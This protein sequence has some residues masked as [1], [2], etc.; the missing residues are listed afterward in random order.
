MK[1]PYG[2]FDDKNREYVITRPDTPLPWLNYI[3]Q[4]QYFGLVTNTSGGYSF[5]RDA[6]LRRLT[7]YRYNDIPYDSNGRYLYICDGKDVWNPGWKPT[8]TKLD[9]YECRH[10]LG[11]T[12]F[13]SE[14]KNVECK[15]K[16]FVPPGENLEIWKT[17]LKN[18][19]KTKKKLRLF[20]FV[21]FCLFE[22]ANDM[23][24]LQRTFS[25]GEVE[26]E[27]GA[28]YHKTEYRER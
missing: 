17:T 11:Y 23:N 8:K 3:G 26:V 1:N 12:Q 13:K 4:E 7:R 9:S 27:G 14:K 19:G 2:H 22:A 6:K 28:I 20:S 16:L 24:N 10:G 18:K 5:W 15:V 25:I 21:E